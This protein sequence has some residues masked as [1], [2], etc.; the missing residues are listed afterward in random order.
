MKKEIIKIE[1]TGCIEG[2]LYLAN[3]LKKILTG[4]KIVTN[5]L[6]APVL[7][8]IQGVDLSMIPVNVDKKPYP[9]GQYNNINI[10]VNPYMMWNDNRILLYKN[11]DII[12]EIT[13][14]DENG[15]LI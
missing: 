13:I 6:I 12:T 3:E 15:I 5:G 9:M 14:I 10:F 7:L 2:K 8:D 4:N 1:N 11:D